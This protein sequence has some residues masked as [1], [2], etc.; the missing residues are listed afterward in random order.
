MKNE[1]KKILLVEDEEHIQM[2][3]KMALELSADYEVAT[4]GNG[5]QMLELYDEFQPDLVLLDVMM[6]KL[7]GPGALQ[8]LK[9]RYPDGHAP[10]VF[11]TAKVQNREQNKYLIMGAVGVIEKP[12]DPMVLAE[13]VNGMWLRYQAGSDD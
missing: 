11:M 4:A 10:V 3:A 1:L 13:T 7:D 2:V 12:F 6:P 5:E 8:E 9:E